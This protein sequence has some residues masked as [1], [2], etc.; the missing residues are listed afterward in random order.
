MLLDK[1]FHTSLLV[2]AH[3]DDEALWFS[4]IIDKVDE[5]VICFLNYNPNPELAIGRK[6]S[7]YQHPM[8]NIVCLEMV[9]S[10]TFNQANWKNPVET[11]FGIELSAAFKSKRKYIENYR[12]LKRALKTKLLNHRNVFTHNPWGEY[13]HEEH[14]Q[15]Y[16]VVEE[17]RQELG[18]NVWFPNY[19]SNKSFPLM[20]RYIS[21]LDSE[22][23]TL[24]TNKVLATRIRDL[25]RKNCCWT[26]YDHW[27]WM[28][29]ESFL[30]KR[31][32]QA[33]THEEYG[34]MFPLNIVGVRSPGKRRGISGSLARVS[35]KVVHALRR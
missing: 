8:K 11:E 29:E 1:T 7:L 16:R 27:E 33:E 4:S 19:C 22:R 25:Y 31:M 13:G 21:L 6:E 12:A 35:A 20:L 10:E 3:P 9:E 14:V 5:V 28:D 2:V 17:L 34:N 23:L 18:F 15:V 26:W 32:D 24:P 30:K